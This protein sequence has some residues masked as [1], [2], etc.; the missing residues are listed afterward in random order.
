[1]VV[2]DSGVWID[3]FNGTPNPSREALRAL[4]R[5]GKAE[6][7]VPDLVLFEVLRGFKAEAD[8]RDARRLMRSFLI[9][10]TGGEALADSA[11]GHYRALRAS[12]LTIR[13]GIDVLIAT[14]CIE[15]EHHLLHADRDY[16]AFEARRGLRVWKH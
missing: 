7:G 8:L 13:N 5:D 15:Q 16:D 10:S 3:Y 9:L 12:G 6:I 2:V 11:V 1:M 14:L 4:L